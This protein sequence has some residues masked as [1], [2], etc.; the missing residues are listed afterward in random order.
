M[1]GWWRRFSPSCRY[2]SRRST[3]EMRKRTAPIMPRSCR[4]ASETTPRNRFGTCCSCTTSA[5]SWEIRC[6]PCDSCSVRW[7]MRTSLTR[8]WKMPVIWMAVTMCWNLK[9]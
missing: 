7:R 1:P 4:K 9:G 6:Q 3:V 8:P 2:A 5:P